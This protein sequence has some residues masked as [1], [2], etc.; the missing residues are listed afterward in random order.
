MRSTWRTRLCGCKRSVEVWQRV[1]AVRSLVLQPTE[2]VE[3]W[4]AFGELCRENDRLR[5]SYKTL[6]S[7]LGEEPSPSAPLPEGC[8]PRVAFSY[9]EHLWASGEQVRRLCTRARV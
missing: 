1:L 4:L 5:L 7:L 8:D 2:A 9:G 3:S 6:S